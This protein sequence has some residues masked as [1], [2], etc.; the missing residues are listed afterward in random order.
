VNTGVVN[1]FV[2]DDNILL[3]IT[4]NSKEDLDNSVV[5]QQHEENDISINSSASIKT[6]P[7]K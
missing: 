1:D 3:E 7:Q 2:E 5:Q 6:P 4:N